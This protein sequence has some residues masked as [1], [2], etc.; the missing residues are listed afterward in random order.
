MHW[1]VAAE[2]GRIPPRDE[3]YLE[4]FTIH[5]SL[6]E[7]EILTHTT[8]KISKSSV[9]RGYLE[10]GLPYLRRPK[11]SRLN[12]RNRKDRLLFSKRWRKKPATFWDNWYFTDEKIFRVDGYDN[13][14]N[15][16]VRETSSKHVE[17]KQKSKYPAH[18]MVHMGMSSKGTGKLRIIPAGETMDGPYY[19]KKIL[20][21]DVPDILSRTEDG[22]RID[23]KVLFDDPD[24]CFYE[25]DYAPPHATRVADQYL[26]QNVPSHNSLLPSRKYEPNWMSA[27]LDDV[28]PIERLW[29]IWCGVVYAPPVPNHIRGILLRVRKAHRET[30]TETL[31]KLV[32]QIP[33]KLQEIYRLKGAR[34][35]PS[36]DYHKNKYKR[37]CEICKN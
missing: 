29:A 36:W 23:E 31:T 3:W 30:T 17:P 13:P 24:N 34:I 25:H 10:L 5:S 18:R 33:A 22:D 28:I 12:E 15:D 27:K 7:S 21:K 26:S 16:G 8:N 20:K 35:H 2:R 11:V 9:S 4:I 14:Q 37:K 19:L 32:H 6:L 1:D